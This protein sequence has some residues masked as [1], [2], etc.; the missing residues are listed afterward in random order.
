MNLNEI[1]IGS[2]IR[3]K[4]KEDGRSALWL[5][6]K[7]HYKRNNLYNIFDKSSI[8]TDVLFK[9]NMALRFDFFVYYSELYRN[10]REDADKDAIQDG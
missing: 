10:M 3:E 1:H 8:D 4:L 5:A 2:L 9:I 7:I 6:E